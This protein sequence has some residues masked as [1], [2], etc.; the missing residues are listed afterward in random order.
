MEVDLLETKIIITEDITNDL[1][2]ILS[3]YAEDKIYVLLD[4]NTEKYCFPLIANVFANKP[5]IVKIQSGEE[6]KNIDTA[7]DIWN[8]LSKNGSD[9]K[10]LIINLGGGVISD[11][12]GFVASSFKRG[13][14][15]INIPTTLLAQIDAAIGGKNGI[16]FN[17]LKNEI[18]FF[19]SPKY[20]LIASEFLKTLESRQIIAGFAEMLKH[21]LIYDI[22][23]WENIKNFNLKKIDFRFLKILME[24]SI[25]IKKYYVE[26]DPHE[27]NIREALN[28]GHTFG[29]AIESFFIN[30][31]IN[32][33]HGEAIAM[34][35]ICELYLSNKILNLNV[36]KMLDVIGFIIDNYKYY[37]IKPNDYDA[38]YELMKH[39]KKNKNNEIRFALLSDI[40]KV[41]VGQVCTKND[42]Y[43]ALGFYFQIMR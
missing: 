9:R 27:A 12:G 26:T 35:L 1:T 11:L 42:I 18:G 36:K 10:S 5:N 19:S 38:I 29:H 41:E 28:F 34:G 25:L 8:Y 23:T 20:I 2:K 13:I 43:Q 22:K 40:G 24:E 14:N 4:E 31:E 3:N 30:K 7:M 16:N 17:N 37:E 32:I 39:D 21:S 15:F 6:M 33:L